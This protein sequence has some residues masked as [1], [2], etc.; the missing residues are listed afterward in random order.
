MSPCSMVRSPASWCGLAPLGPEPTTVKSTWECPCSVS[1]RARSAAT[2]VSLRPEK[3]TLRIS[4]YV[5]SAA[6]PAAA[7]RA[8]SWASFTARSI[9]SAWVSE[10][11][12]VSGSR[13]W[14]P[15]RCMAQALSLI[16]NRP[17][18]SSSGAVTSY[19]S[20]PSVQSRRVMAGAPTAFAA[21][22]ASSVGTTSTGSWPAARTRSVRRSV[23]AGGA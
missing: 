5:A 22:G 14:R 3:R 2:S 9:G 6:A 19:G 17:R 20:L 18:A 8:S 10:A 13:C 15:S 12:E 16:P 11:Y 23:S 4:S 1:S 21:S 7:I